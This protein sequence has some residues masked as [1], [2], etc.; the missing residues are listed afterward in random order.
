MPRHTINHSYRSTRDGQTFGPWVQGDEIEVS[1]EDA[2]WLERDSP[3]LIVVTQAT[4]KRDA[5]D[6]QRQ[7]K[8]IPNRGLKGSR[9]R[10]I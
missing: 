10:A 2:E 1:A 4:P 8:E 5:E 6:A 9:N 7:A 3:G